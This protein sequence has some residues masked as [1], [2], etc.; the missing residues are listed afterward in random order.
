[1]PGKGTMNVLY[2]ATMH[3]SVYAF[4]AD[5]TSGTAPL[6]Q[7][8]LGAAVDPAS[9]N[10]AG[11]EPYTDILNEIGILSTPVIDRA[12]NTI[13]VVNETPDGRPCRIL[14]A[15]AGPYHRWRE[16]E[17]TRTDPGDRCRERMGRYGRRR[18]W[19]S[20]RS[21]RRSICKGPVCCW[22]M[23]RVRRVWIAWRLRPLAWLDRRLQ[24][25]EPA[26][27]D[28]RFQYHALH[29]RLRPLARRPRT[30]GRCGGQCLLFNRQR[31]LRRRDVVGRDRAAPDPWTGRGGLVHSGRVRRLDRRRHGLRF[32]RAHSRA[33][34]ELRDCG[35]QG[36]AGRPDRPHRHGRP[37]ARYR[38]AA[39]LH[40]GSQMPI[41]HLQCGA[42]ESRGRPCSLY[43]GRRPCAARIPD[44]ERRIQ[45]HAA[46]DQ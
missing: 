33:G 31:Q 21:R 4:D 30:G 27:T 10:I 41:R 43:L 26:A 5:G 28:R 25:H 24:R 13:Y 38:R 46:G 6:W 34:H 44:A 22:P 42:L 29:G 9:F 15:R 2:V 40:G 45:Y 16:I 37:A 23:V 3:N 14:P 19:P 7:V 20:C 18:E 1:M 11:A 32:Q 12:G 8:N 35:R 17:R 39:I 36:G